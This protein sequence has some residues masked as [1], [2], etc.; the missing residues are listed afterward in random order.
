MNRTLLYRDEMVKKAVHQLV[1]PC[2]SVVLTSPQTALTVAHPRKEMVKLTLGGEDKV[3]GLEEF[4]VSFANF[5]HRPLVTP[6]KYL[7]LATRTPFRQ[8]S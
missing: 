7:H 2:Y 6:V 8:L 5:V 1:S 4:S 3:T